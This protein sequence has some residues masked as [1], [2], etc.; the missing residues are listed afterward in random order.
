MI[1]HSLQEARNIE[2]CSK[3]QKSYRDYRLRT[4]EKR[5]L[6]EENKKGKKKGTKGKRGK[7]K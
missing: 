5:K 1:F 6:E 4:E 3:I 2:A 7:R